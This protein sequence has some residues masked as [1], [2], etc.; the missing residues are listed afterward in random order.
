MTDFTC[1]TTTLVNLQ[2]RFHSSLRCTYLTVTKPSDNSQ[3][4]MHSCNF[5]I[6]HDELDPIERSVICHRKEFW[7]YIPVGVRTQ[8]MS[9]ARLSTSADIVHRHQPERRFIFHSYRFRERAT[10]GAKY[11]I[12]HLAWI[13]VMHAVFTACHH[14]NPSSEEAGNLEHCT[15]RLIVRWVVGILAMLQRIKNG[16]QEGKIATVTI[17][18]IY[19]SCWSKM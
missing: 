3:W 12:L 13:S 5:F 17:L 16:F 2:Y 6:T 1:T 4:N 11:H 18:L 14:R 7:I 15:T 8:H 9:A 19:V 10:M